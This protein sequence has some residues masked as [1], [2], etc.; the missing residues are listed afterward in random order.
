MIQYLYLPDYKQAH[1]PS[2]QL[3]GSAQNAS[4]PNLPLQ[5]K[6]YAIGDNYAIADLKALAVVR[7]KPSAGEAWNTRFSRCGC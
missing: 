7:F 6:V 2:L 3:A 1:D 5:V 4:A